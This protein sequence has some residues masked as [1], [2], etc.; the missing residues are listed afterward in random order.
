[1]TAKERRGRPKKLKRATG[2]RPVKRT[3]RI[4][5]EGEATEPEYIDLIRRL[6]EVEASTSVAISVEER[7]ATPLTLVTSACD[8]KRRSNLDIDEYWCVFDVENPKPHPHLADACVKA[9]DNGVHIAV[10]NP[11]FELW[12]I[13]HLRDCA[14]SLSTEEAIRLRRDLDGSDLKHLDAEKYRPHIDDAVRR[15]RKLRDKHIKDGSGF[16]HDNPSSSFDL[17][18]GDLMKAAQ[19]LADQNV[20]TR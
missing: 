18:V 9:R 11:C 14:K 16:P 17:F 6:P 10:S 8:D 2:V 4:Y 12:L 15:A 5:A 1:M 3:F 13:L 7:G 19:P 20:T